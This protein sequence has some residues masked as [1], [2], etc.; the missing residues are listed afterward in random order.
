MIEENKQQKNKRVCSNCNSE[1]TAINHSR[2]R[3][4]GTLLPPYENWF[5]DGKGGWLCKKCRLKKVE[6][7]KFN[8]IYNPINHPIY[9]PRRLTY[10]GKVVMLK[11]AP[12]IGVC[13]LC[14]AVV[15]FDCGRTQMHH[16]EYDDTNP[17]AHTIEACPRCHIETKNFDTEK[18]RTNIE[19]RK[20]NLKIMQRDDKG[21]IIA[22]NVREMKER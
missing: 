4:D 3:K 17:L 21:R 12:R 2:K 13:N 9:N 8:P 14:R 20:Q 16:E 7:P 15:P 11:E 10:K 18:M 6:H 5:R 1:T 22:S 19:W